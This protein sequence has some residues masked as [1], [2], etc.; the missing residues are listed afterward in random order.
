MRRS[1][2]GFLGF[3]L[4]K[5]ERANSSRKITSGSLRGKSFLRR[6]DKASSTKEGIELSEVHRWSRGPPCW[7]SSIKASQSWTVSGF[8][9]VDDDDDDC[10]CEAG[11]LSVMTGET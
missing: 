1:R 5:N 10:G 11:G 9:V 3:G 7:K 8:N 6:E 4:E 2:E